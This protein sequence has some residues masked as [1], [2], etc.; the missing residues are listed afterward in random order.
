MNSDQISSDGSVSLR[1]HV[2]D[3]QAEKLHERLM[4][5]SLG[6]VYNEEQHGPELVVHIR[7]RPTQE[8]S[9][10]KLFRELGVLVLGEDADSS[11]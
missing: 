9:V 1:A 11:L 7:C 10:R 2:T 6:I 3:S 5:A 8:V 4:T